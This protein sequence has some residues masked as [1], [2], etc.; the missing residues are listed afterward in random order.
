M[1][2]FTGWRENPLLN[3]WW[4]DTR[5]RRGGFLLWQIIL[6]AVLIAHQV[7]LPNEH[8][9]KG[10]VGGAVVGAM[11]LSL[12]VRGLLLT[13]STHG[14]QSWI[15]LAL[16]ALSPTERYW[17][18][19]LPLLIESAPMVA[20]TA[21]FAAL[22]WIGGPP[23]DT[24]VFQD[25]LG[26]LGYGVIPFIGAL[27]TGGLWTLL[28]KSRVKAGF[29]YFGFFMLYEIC[30]CSWVLF[31]SNELGNADFNWVVDLLDFHTA[32]L[33]LWAMSLWLLPG[34][35]VALR[36]GFGKE[37]RNYRRAIGSALRWAG[38]WLA[39]CLIFAAFSLLLGGA[40]RLVPEPDYTPVTA[41][42]RLDLESWRYLGGRDTL[43][44][45]NDT[46]VRR[47]D[48]RL[49]ESLD[50]SIWLHHRLSFGGQQHDYYQLRR[51]FEL[52]DGTLWLSSGQGVIVVPPDW[53]SH[54]DRRLPHALGYSA[55][56]EFGIELTK[57]DKLVRLAHQPPHQR[58]DGLPRLSVHDV[59]G[60]QMLCEFALPFAGFDPLLVPDKRPGV[61]TVWNRWQRRLSTWKLDGSLKRRRTLIGWREWL[62]ESRLEVPFTRFE[63]CEAAVIDEDGDAYFAR[64]A[65][66]TEAREIEIYRLSAS[67]GRIGRYSLEA[68]GEGKIVGALRIVN[69][70]LAV[71]AWKINPDYNR[72]M[73][74][75]PEGET[76]WKIFMIPLTEFED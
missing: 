40:L 5:R 53:N 12:W 10:W 69:G 8:T 72:A 73:R 11:L 31:M 32:P 22:N 57:D 17:G 24:N 62:R 63:D 16:T 25:S 49:D 38:W 76:D 2:V 43:L 54:N 30:L 66:E 61:A 33:A 48:E 65:R 58:F 1:F 75:V 4:R 29:G 42:A 45:S 26:P 55:Y 52:E 39:L 20:S 70:H 35:L 21:V 44:F 51:A 3:L 56:G 71:L 46:V 34:P 19:M 23:R 68:G 64:H 47:L 36:L 7:F 41:S 9:I 37:L 74:A 27:L 6:G 60:W 67:G 14:R 28:T 15:D 59:S 13:I 50:D 18:R